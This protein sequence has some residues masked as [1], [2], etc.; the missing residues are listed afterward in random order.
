MANNGLAASHQT[1]TH[2]QGTNSADGSESAKWLLKAAAAAMKAFIQ[3]EPAT[4]TTKTTTSSRQLMRRQQ[5]QQEQRE[6]P[7]SGCDIPPSSLRHW[8][9]AGLRPFERSLP[10][11][12]P[13]LLPHKF[14][15]A[16]GLGGQRRLKR[17]RPVGRVKAK[18]G[19]TGEKDVV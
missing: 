9:K 12:F 6:R 3:S 15:R 1:Q 10:P 19:G 18:A 13:P 2:R 8:A 11:S 7:S 17:L 16:H 5:G 14:T 4:V